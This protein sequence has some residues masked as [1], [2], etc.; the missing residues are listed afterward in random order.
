[1]GGVRRF[2]LLLAALEA[3]ATPPP[4]Q[5]PLPTRDF[6]AEARTA[7]DRLEASFYTHWGSIE[8]T[9]EVRRLGREHVA[10][11]REETDANSHRALMALRVLARLAPEERFSPAAKAILYAGALAREGDFTRWGVVAPTGFLPGVYGQELL[12]LGTVSTPYLR[13]LLRERRRAPV[14]RE[15]A[16]RIQGDRLCDY[17][18][19]FLATLYDRPL[20]YHA[21]PDLRDEQIR[22]LDLWLDRRR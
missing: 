2:V 15:P 21:D 14:Q 13:P 19:V 17:A 22:Q 16:G 12:E 8:G 18:W 11:L 1:M 10:A 9:P 5:P 7:L 6:R 20:A 3:C 4:P